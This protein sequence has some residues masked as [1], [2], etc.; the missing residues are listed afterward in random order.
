M[1]NLNLKKINN[2]EEIKKG[3]IYALMNNV[4]LNKAIFDGKSI[5]FRAYEA[6]SEVETIDGEL[7]VKLK[8]VDLFEQIIVTERVFRMLNMYEVSNTKTVAET[9]PAELLNTTTTVVEQARHIRKLEKKVRNFKA[10]LKKHDIATN[11]ESQEL[12]EF[13]KKIQKFRRSFAC[14]IVDRFSE[15]IVGFNADIIVG[16]NYVD[17]VEVIIHVDKESNPF[18][19]LE[20]DITVSARAIVHPEDEFNY[21]T[22]ANLALMRAKVK[23]MEQILK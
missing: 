19:K 5:S 10:I 13:A 17:E 15:N 6:V 9:S 1:N 18:E 3:K 11:E 7:E 21:N 22:G 4:D 12:R 23:L 8:T 20:R 2:I 16:S 14:A